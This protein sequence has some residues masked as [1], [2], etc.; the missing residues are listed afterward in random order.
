MAK[1]K[2]LLFKPKWQ[3]K[4]PSIRQRAVATSE[5][6]RL[7]EALPELARGDPSARVR[8]AAL[9]RID[10]IYYLMR[11]AA[12]DDDANVRETAYRG[13]RALLAGEHASSLAM[14]QRLEI[15]PRLDD[16]A[17]LEYLARRADDAGVRRAAVV[18]LDKPGLL[19]DVAIEDP[20]PGLRRLAIERI[21]Q[22][23]TLERVAEALRTR[24]KTAHRLALERLGDGEGSADGT[25][26]LTR[27][28]E[29][30]EALARSGRPPEEK[31]RELE[32]LTGEWAKHPEELKKPLQKRFE[33]ACNIVRKILEA[34]RK[35]PGDA[36]AQRALRSEFEGVLEDAQG[37][38]ERSE[39]RPIDPLLARLRGLRGPAAD[40]LGED[41][42]RRIDAARERLE[43]L[44]AKLLA[45]QPVNPNLLAISR[46]ADQLDPRRCSPR[47][48]ERLEDRWAEAWKAIDHPT[49]NEVALGDAFRERL[50]H[51]REALEERERAREEALAVIDE[52][53]AGL[54]TRLDE[55]D[56]AGAAR[57]QQRILDTL[58]RIGRHPHLDDT[59]FKA[60]LHTAKGRLHELREW[61]HWANNKI[62]TQ[63]CEEAEGIPEAGLHPDAVV[64]KI[65]ALR[66]KW[67]ELNDSERLPGDN[68]KKMP[69][70]GL[71]RRFQDA[72]DRAFKPAR[73]FF[74]KRDEVRS[75]H[76]DKLDALARRIEAAVADPE[77]NDWKVLERL[78]R[79][80]RRSLRELPEIPPKKRG[81]MSR[82]LREGAQALDDRLE[83]HYRIV[84]RRKERLIEEVRGLDPEADL[85]AAI[86]AAKAAQQSWKEAGLTR[87]RREQKL[88][89]VFREASDRVFNHLEEQRKEERAIEK[90][91]RAKLDELLA[92]ARALPDLAGRDPEEASA[93]LHRLED[94]WRRSPGQ[95]RR[96]ERHFQDKVEE[97]RAQIRTA[98]L[99]V[100]LRARR[101]LRD[102]TQ[103][104][105][106]VERRWFDDSDEDPAALREQARSLQAAADPPKA[107]VERLSRAVAG[108][109]PE[110]L[111]R[112]AAAHREQG[113]AI[114]VALEF[115]AGID[116]PQAFRQQRMDYQVQRLSRRMSGEDTVSLED[117]SWSLEQ[118]WY[119]CGPLAPGDAAALGERFDRATAAIDEARRKALDRA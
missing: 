87:R 36:P 64:Q 75:A 14:E 46:E 84:E 115:L 6:P 35:P 10:D 22:R 62:R 17:M 79:D 70:P 54:E 73:E 48:L 99:E 80:G 41:A 59:D 34:K 52:R 65:K 114:C 5:D 26:N 78:V 19:G 56:L 72:A 12:E 96:R 33:G 50:S 63:L 53:V 101:A 39:L 86:E 4:D 18:K 13:Y 8:L 28:C 21:D 91:H 76:F 102:L 82:R 89:K 98:E 107:L 104:C 29:S 93:A 100:D 37:L 113:E 44:R 81:P 67:R 42:A 90:A 66:S 15:V 71:Y 60:R 111:D 3:H 109:A 51:L 116:S 23:S 68:P 38:A 11:I 9:R 20:D 85:S 110:D 47:R 45:D 88:W 112:A 83:D 118:D 55:G 16:Q 106:R 43:Q 49:P 7:L 105:H 1:L 57:A 119:A 92:E 103:V 77:A 69:A 97:T 27:I 117:E 40:E 74:E 2:E 32:R 31:E 25:E 58:E 94:R 95:D 108:E 61:Q 24:D 30:A